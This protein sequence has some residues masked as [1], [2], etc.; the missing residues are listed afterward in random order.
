MSR[1]QGRKE[2]SE[3]VTGVAWFK[4]EEWEEW[5]KEC[6]EFEETYAEWEAYALERF[7]DFKRQGLSI[8]T[9]VIGV[10]AFLT[11]C[12][13]TGHSPDGSARRLTSPSYLRVDTTDRRGDQGV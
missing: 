8:Q 6:P 10:K 5:R 3:V 2:G 4:P 12:D 9:V 1:K 7:R 11:W 13:I